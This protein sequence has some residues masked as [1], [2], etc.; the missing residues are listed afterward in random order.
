M[1]FEKDPVKLNGRHFVSSQQHGRGGFAVKI[2]HLT[3]VP[4]MEESHRGF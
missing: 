2:H 4:P 3:N 1:H